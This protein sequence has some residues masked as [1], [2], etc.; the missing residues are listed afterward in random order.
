MG[1][2][3]NDKGAENDE[4]PQHNVDLPYDYYLGRFPITR[5]QYA[6]YVKAKSVKQPLNNWEKK[7]VNNWE[8]KRDHPVVNVSWDDAMA[9]CKWLDED[10]KGKPPAGLV[11]RLPTEAEWEKA[12]RG[13]MGMTYPWGDA[14]DKNNCN[15][16][17]GGKG[18]T[19]PVG[20]Y[21]P[22]GDSP[23]GC[24]DMSGNVWEWTYSLFK[25]Y[26]YKAHD[27]REDEN[28][29]GNRVLRGGSYYYGG[30]N[31]RCACRYFDPVGSFI[32]VRGFRV[33][34]SP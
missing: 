13:E 28:A 1:S 14:F 17:E 3:D 26:P 18:S 30:M 15:T 10:L 19:T 29:S 25:P 20:A 22:Q 8:R 27:G 11:L 23:Y 2:A 31:A 16:S 6:M 34:A 4:K 33:A 12:A 21:S 24:A 5:E 7:H 32:D 9:Y